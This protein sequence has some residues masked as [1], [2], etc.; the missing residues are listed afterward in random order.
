MKAARL[1]AMKKAGKLRVVVTYAALL[2]TPV[3]SALAET[4]VRK[5]VQPASITGGQILQLITALIGIVALIVIMAWL[6][7]RTGRINVNTNA[8]F[9]IVGMV[10][11]GTRERIVLMQVGEQQIL[12]G[13][14][15][16]GGIRTLHVLDKN[17][18]I[19]EP[20]HGGGFQEKL[21]GL[22]DRSRSK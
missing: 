3:A 16:Q 11:M 4:A 14:S 13:V 12:I 8:G 5:N 9:R 15:Q 7:R 10:P 17:I 6:V 22:L 2:M 1:Y 20:G 21:R 19:G 18:D